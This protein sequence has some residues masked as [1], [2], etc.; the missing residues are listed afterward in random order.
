MTREEQYVRNLESKGCGYY[1]V[2]SEAGHS[3]PCS[4]S[5]EVMQGYSLKVW[6]S[7]EKDMHD[8]SLTPGELQEF[9]LFMSNLQDE[10][11]LAEEVAAELRSLDDDDDDGD[12]DE[13]HTER[14]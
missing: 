2:C 13:V 4:S 11:E 1:S 7:L 5:S 6:Q 3:C 9:D 14:F 10:R 8:N 12:D